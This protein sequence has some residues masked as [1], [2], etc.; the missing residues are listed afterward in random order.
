MVKRSGNL[1]QGVQEFS[2][3]TICFQPDLFK[4]FVTLEKLPRIEQF[5]AAQVLSV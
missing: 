5:D 4:L 1:D 3:N 2:L